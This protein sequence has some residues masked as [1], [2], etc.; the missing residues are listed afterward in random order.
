MATASAASQR[1]RDA[2]APDIDIVV[3]RDRAEKAILI[4]TRSPR[5]FTRRGLVLETGKTLDLGHDR[6]DRAASSRAPPHR[7][8]AIRDP[9]TLRQV[10]DA[11]QLI[12]HT[13]VSHRCA[14]PLARRRAGVDLE[15]QV[16]RSDAGPAKIGAR[17]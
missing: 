8:A 12:D 1:T 14:I 10:V 16:R 6:R 15:R 4:A 7:D 13:P 3:D 9:A 11:D 2:R 17:R 5:P